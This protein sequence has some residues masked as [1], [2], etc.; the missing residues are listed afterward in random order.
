MTH[1]QVSVKST[2][3]L[4]SVGARMGRELKPCI[5]GSNVYTVGQLRDFCTKHALAT[6]T[7]ITH[8]AVASPEHEFSDPADLARAFIQKL[9]NQ[10]KD[11]R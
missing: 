9:L 8:A 4:G 2:L 11:A 1:W 10:P 7:R 6:M 3:P 5:P